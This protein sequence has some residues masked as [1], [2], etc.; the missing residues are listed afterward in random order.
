VSLIGQLERLE[1]DVNELRQENSAQ[2]DLNE[3]LI[4]RLDALETA[5]EKVQTSQQR[6]PSAQPAKAAVKA[7]PT[8]K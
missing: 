2:R 4:A 7:V 6:H 5:I 3:S 8:S 1:R